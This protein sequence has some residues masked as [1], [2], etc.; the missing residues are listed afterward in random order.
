M[1]G[2]SVAEITYQPSFSP[3]FWRS[4]NDSSPWIGEAVFNSHP[5]S[6]QFSSTLP[7]AQNLTLSIE[8]PALGIKLVGEIVDVQVENGYRVVSF[9]SF[10]DAG[11]TALLTVRTEQSH[12]VGDELQITGA[13]LSFRTSE[14]RPRPLFIVDTFYAMLGLF[15]AARI[16][17]PDV[18]VDLTLHFNIQLSELSEL[19]QRR[20]MYLGLMVIEKATGLG[21]DVPEYISGEEMSAIFF[22][23]RAI[24]ERDFIWRVNNIVQPTP[25][26]DETFNWFQSLTS[27]RPDEF[28]YKMVFGPSPVK[29][30]IFGKDISLG[31]QTVFIEDGIIEDRVNVGRELARKDG[32][33]VTVRI[34]PRSAVG[35]YV[36]P[37]APTLPASSWDE[38]VQYLI[39]LDKTLG[40]HL[41]AKYLALMSLVVPELPPEQV[42]ALINPETIAVLAEQARE[43]RTPV[44]E[45]LKSLLT[46]TQDF[47]ATAQ[48]SDADFDTAMELFAEGT[49]DLPP[50]SGT[51]SREDIYFDHD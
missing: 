39:D 8:L 3:G 34:T 42:Y 17:I 29:R 23:S 15:G 6:P 20:Q 50:Y 16:S 25:A 36:L 48:K 45:Y 31:D 37:G 41:A 49:E 18:N 5:G 32:R 38:R 44:D 11:V 40:Q 1:Q 28:V 43:R 14:H 24:R 9:E 51:Y 19:L 46:K 47:R 21:F 10:I 2:M 4:E 7:T 22:V 12:G 13:S 33:L 27:S 35:R 26:N 30:L